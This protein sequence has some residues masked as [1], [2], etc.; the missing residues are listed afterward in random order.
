MPWKLQLEALRRS[1]VEH[2]YNLQLEN[3]HTH[4]TIWFVNEVVEIL[5]MKHI[6]ILERS[7]LAL[8]FPRTI[9][10]IIVSV[11][12]ILHLNLQQ[13]IVMET[14]SSWDVNKDYPEF[15]KLASLMW[16]LFWFS[17]VLFVVHRTV[18]IFL[19]YSNSLVLFLVKYVLCVLMCLLKNKYICSYM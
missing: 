6:G 19:S 10:N 12:T 18:S 17:D 2:S 3:C 9:P 11:Q 8:I 15:S 4:N 7:A 14:Q 13:N 1:E 16:M 5:E